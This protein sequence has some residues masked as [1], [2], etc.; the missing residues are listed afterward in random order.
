MGAFVSGEVSSDT[1]LEYTVIGAIAVIVLLQVVSAVAYYNAIA[2]H[3]KLAGVGVAHSSV[4]TDADAIVK[5]CN[6]ELESHMP[7]PSIPFGVW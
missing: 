7:R 1:A 4:D 3:E 2:P 6:A 5:V